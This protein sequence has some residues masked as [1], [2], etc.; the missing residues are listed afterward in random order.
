MAFCPGYQLL[1]SLGY[2]AQATVYKAVAND[3]NDASQSEQKRVAVKIFD[4]GFAGAARAAMKSELHYLTQSQGHPNVIRLVEYFDDGV[5]PGC[6]VLELCSKDLW[7][8]TNRQ[9]FA[10]SRAIEIIRGVLSALVYVHELNIVHRDVKPENVSLGDDGCPRL[11]DFGIATYVTD[12][13]QMRRFPGSPGY[14]APELCERKAYGLLV[15]EFAAGATFYYILS[16]K[17]A[18][19]TPTMTRTSIIARTIECL[20]SYDCDFDGVSQHSREAIIWLMHV[21]SSRRPAAGRVLRHPPF[22]AW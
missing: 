3:S 22:V 17:L 21:Q 9:A 20:V 5:R 1:R 11:M 16:G 10:E 12:E 15:D 18:F 6:I 19:A 14:A 4:A 13:E 2:G 8:L 7:R